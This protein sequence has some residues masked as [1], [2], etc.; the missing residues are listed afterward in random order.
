MRTY[1]PITLN[2]F[3]RGFWLFGYRN[4]MA[5]IFPGLIFLC[6]AISHWLPTW[7]PRY[8][9]MLAACIFIQVAMFFAG[10]ETKDELLVICLFHFLGL[11]MELFKVNMG[12][13]SYPD[14][15][16]TKIAGVP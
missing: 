13:W 5:C 4:A 9:F 8:D 3:L 6:L 15:A 1:P 12:S 14:A 10:L 7:L 2:E 11:M 16:Y